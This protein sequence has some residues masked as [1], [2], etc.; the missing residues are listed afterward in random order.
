MRETL[1]ELICDK[2]RV[3]SA[4][5]RLMTE[6]ADSDRTCKPGV[7]TNQKY[8]FGASSYRATQH[9]GSGPLGGTAN[10]TIKNVSP[11]KKHIIFHGRLHTS[12]SP[13]GICVI[14]A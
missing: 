5:L 7:D 3:Q 4:M 1:N 10:L 13:D 6:R 11:K 2:G 8:H 12:N 14:I 9:Y